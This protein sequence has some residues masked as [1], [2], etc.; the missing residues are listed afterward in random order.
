MSG[1]SLPVQST[2]SSSSFICTVAGC[3]VY[4]AVLGTGVNGPQSNG[5][6][7]TYRGHGGA[8][9]RAFVYGPDDADFEYHFVASGMTEDARDALRACLMALLAEKQTTGSINR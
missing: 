4:T 2:I 9:R 8:V 3:D 7:V 6:Y 5:F 1:P